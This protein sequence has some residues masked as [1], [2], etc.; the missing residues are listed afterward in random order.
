MPIIEQTPERYLRSPR[1]EPAADGGALLHV[2]AW[3][4]DQECILR[5]NLSAEGEVLGDPSAT[6]HAAAIMTWAPGM[7]HPVD[8]PGAELA[9]AHQGWRV[10][11]RHEGPR[12][13]VAVVAPTGTEF[14]V[15]TAFGMAAAPCIS[16]APGGAWV[17]F[18]HDVRE[19][20]GVPD[21]AKWIAVR[22]VDMEGGVFEPAAPMTGRDRDLGGEEQGFEFPTLVVCL[23]YTSPSP[24]DLN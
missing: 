12:S 13:S 10:E 4:G 24:R 15:W 23:L 1:L 22:F 11:V 14:V 16:A 18:H 6:D 3:E 20:T 9:D 7:V 5:F 17:A 2:L 19:D 8:D 21:I